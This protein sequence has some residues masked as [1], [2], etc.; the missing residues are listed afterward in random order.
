MSVRLGK[1]DDTSANKQED[2]HLFQNKHYL[3]NAFLQWIQSD[4]GVCLS[5]SVQ[6]QTGA[7]GE[8][9]NPFI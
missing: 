3:A 7:G 2:H 9:G 4:S 6:E 5:V 8:G 1:P